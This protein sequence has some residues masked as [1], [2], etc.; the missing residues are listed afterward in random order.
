MREVFIYS[1]FGG[2]ELCKF[3]DIGNGVVEFV[4][5]FD[6]FYIK[7]SLVFFYCVLVFLFVMVLYIWC[8]C[9][10]KECILIF[11]FLVG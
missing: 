3:F 4:I 8:Y 7:F 1:K 6:E 5:C 10:L 2:V 11:D 9:M